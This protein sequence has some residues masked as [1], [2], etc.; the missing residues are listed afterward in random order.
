MKTIFSW[1]G[2]MTLCFF[3]LV[4]S[5]YSIAAGVYKYKDK[6]GVWHFTDTPTEMTDSDTEKIIDDATIEKKISDLEKQ[7]SE[8][9][10]PQNNIENAR[11]ATVSIKTEL[12]NGSGFFITDDG[13]ILTNKHV[14][15]GME[16]ELEKGK[17]AFDKMK[18]YLDE[19]EQYLEKEETW[20]EKER[21]WLTEAKDELNRVSQLV[22]SNQ[23]RLTVAESNYYNAYVSEYNV[24]NG[25]FTRKQA[26]YK[27]KEAEFKEKEKYF[28]QHYKKFRKLRYNRASQKGFKIILADKT[29]LTAEK[30]AFSDRYDL[31]LL[32]ISGYKTPFIK[33][34]KMDEIAL[35]DPL[36]AIG[37]PLSFDHSVTSGIFSGLRENM[38]QTNAQVS[39]GNSG[40]PLITKNG[41][42][43]GI[44]T[45][46][47]VHQSVE[48]IS[49][50][51]SI[52]IA[53]REFKGYWE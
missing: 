20:L 18:E 4:F 53:L 17:A 50:A 29:E 28:N 37:N 25:I 19:L 16:N 52:D 27:H 48:G 46:K 38:I 35:G 44:N 8:K 41:S 23:K 7:L 34:A 45:K 6:N 12:S 42:V 1:H 11:N 15:H 22:K 14:I 36:Y 51:I 33:P 2:T 5:A 47:I 40:G 49:F 9:M 31:A 10:P 30:V 24:R 43:V 13:Y 32:K 21:E 3:T 26:Y 39:P